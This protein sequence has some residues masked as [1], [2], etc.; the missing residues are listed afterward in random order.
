M[1]HQQPGTIGARVIMCRAKALRD[2]K[3]HGSDTPAEAF[4][5]KAFG[6]DLSLIH[7]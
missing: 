3:R 6:R 4:Y 2:F 5:A 7:I 1:L